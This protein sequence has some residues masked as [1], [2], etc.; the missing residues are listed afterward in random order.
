MISK[1][2]PFDSL[3]SLRITIL[4]LF[5]SFIVSVIAL[6]GVSRQPTLL[7]ASITT[8]SWFAFRRLQ[9]L[10]L[11]PEFKYVFGMFILIWLSHM[12]SLLWNVQT[13][14]QR[15]DRSKNQWITAYKMLFNCRWIGTS[16]P[17]PDLVRRKLRSKQNP[18]HIDKIN[19][20]RLVGSGNLCLNQKLKWFFI[21]RSVIVLTMYL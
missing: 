14:T 11:P 3:L 16:R 4:S 10:P 21:R 15:V 12:A 9:Q 2:D 18:S 5:A 8:L 17:A 20:D 7:L 13:S 6:N 1:V 19:Q